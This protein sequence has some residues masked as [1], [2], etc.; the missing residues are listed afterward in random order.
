MHIQ[1]AAAKFGT[2]AVKI[3]NSA[4]ELSIEQ[5]EVE[6]NIGD[7]ASY[8]GDIVDRYTL[9]AGSQCGDTIEDGH[10]LIVIVAF[11]ISERWNNGITVGE[12]IIT[13][14]TIGCAELE[15]CKNILISQHILHK[16]FSGDPPGSGYGRKITY[17]VIGCKK[18][19]GIP[20]ACQVNIVTV[21]VSI[22]HTPDITDPR[23]TVIT[24]LVSIRRIEIDQRQHI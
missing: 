8:P 10:W 11:H 14:H 7:G 1:L 12:L 3:F 15:V 2:L 20:S 18:I 5:G 23:F 22:A 21:I 17:A 6:T 9:I 16:F 24:V 4:G 19:R 13:Q